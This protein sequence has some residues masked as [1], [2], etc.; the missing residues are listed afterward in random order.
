MYI[1]SIFRPLQLLKTA[2]LCLSL[3]SAAAG[4][5]SNNWPLG[6]PRISVYPSVGNNCT[7]WHTTRP[8]YYYA[9][10]SIH[11]VWGWLVGCCFLRHCVEHVPRWGSMPDTAQMVQSKWVDKST[12]IAHETKISN[13]RGGGLDSTNFSSPRE[14]PQGIKGKISGPV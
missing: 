12:S 7:T 1:H 5:I 4:L 14:A 13:W 9:V 6:F 3:V 10:Y 8:S 2:S 11:T